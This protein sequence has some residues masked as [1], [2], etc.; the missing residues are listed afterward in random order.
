MKKFLE[1]ALSVAW[2]GEP[3]VGNERVSG[4]IMTKH[5]LN[6]LEP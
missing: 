3:E 1:N 5:L 4:A 2:L 6:P